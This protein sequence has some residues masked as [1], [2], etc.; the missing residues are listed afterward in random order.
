MSVTGCGVCLCFSLRYRMLLLFYLTP[1]LPTLILLLYCLCA[2][3]ETSRPPSHSLFFCLFG[4]FPTV[5]ECG[6]K[7]FVFVCVGKWGERGETLLPDS[8]K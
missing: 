5:S 4:I 2:T 1:S 3:Q 8:P 6:K 7:V